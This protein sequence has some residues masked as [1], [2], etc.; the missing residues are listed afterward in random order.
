M[1]PM[2]FGIA[3]ISDDSKTYAKYVYDRLTG[4][5]LKAKLDTS[6][7]KIGY[8]IREMSL[9]K[10][11]YILTIGRK[12]EASHTV[13]VRILGE[14]NTIDLSLDE[15]INKVKMKIKLKEKNYSL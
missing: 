4:E 9:E 12:E 7:E 2:K 10:I 15:L 3:N 8:K 6:N 5:G 1:N 13:N 11:P 14:E